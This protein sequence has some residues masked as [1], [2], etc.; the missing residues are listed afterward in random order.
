MNLKDPFI[1]FPLLIIINIIAYGLNISFSKIWDRIYS[2]HTSISKKEIL[3]SLLILVLNIAVAFPGFILWSNEI[4]VFSNDNFW[5]SFIGLFLLIDFLMYV[6]HWVSHNISYLRKIHSKHHEH[7][8]KFNCV[9]LYYMSPWESVLFGLL[10]TTVTILFSF[11]L[12]SFISFLLFNWFYGVITHLN[13]SKSK[14][15]F[16]I[17]TTNTFHHNHHQLNGVNY[18]FYTFLWDRIFKTEMKH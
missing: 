15:H 17:F 4:I 14:P 6:S 11:N 2:H 7:S 12:Y 5:L 3:L 8:I 10:L 16:L 13:V 9:S 18:G 1:F